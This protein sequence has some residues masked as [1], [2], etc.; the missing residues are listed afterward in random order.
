MFLVSYVDNMVE[1]RLLSVAFPDLDVMS[2]EYVLI[3]D[4]DRRAW[5]YDSPSGTEVKH[6]LMIFGLGPKKKT[7]LIRFLDNDDKAPI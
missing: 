5:F 3:V 4:L 7:I 6:D 2:W 1:R